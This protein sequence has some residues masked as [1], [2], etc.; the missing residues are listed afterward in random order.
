M[1]NSAADRRSTPT[2]FGIPLRPIG[3]IVAWNRE[4]KM[5]IPEESILRVQRVQ[6]NRWKNTKTGE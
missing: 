5:E 4:A 2:R 6:E 3:C 1:K